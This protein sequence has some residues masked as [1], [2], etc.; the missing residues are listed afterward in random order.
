MA[1]TTKGSIAELF[2]L[3]PNHNLDHPV[4]PQPVCRQ[5]SIPSKAVR[6]DGPDRRGHAVLRMVHTVA[7]YANVAAG[8]YNRP[9]WFWGVVGLVDRSDGGLLQD[10]LPRHQHLFAAGVSALLLCVESGVASSPIT[11]A[12]RGTNRFMGRYKSVGAAW[13]H[14]RAVWQTFAPNSPSPTTRQMFDVYVAGS[15]AGMKPRAV[16]ASE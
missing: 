12:C 1:K 13:G 11:K 16:A 6:G 7:P 3:G 15:N 14:R 4:F 8:V 5:V 2:T 10:A 9:I